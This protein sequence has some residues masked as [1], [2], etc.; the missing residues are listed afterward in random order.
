MKKTYINPSMEIVKIQM[1]QHL[2]DGSPVVTMSG[3]NAENA[4]M[5]REFD[6]DFDED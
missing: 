3:K 2:L 4:G 6:F 5:G 1:N